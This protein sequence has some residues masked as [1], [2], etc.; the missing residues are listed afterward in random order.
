MPAL[1]FNK[2]ATLREANGTIVDD[3]PVA[4]WSATGGNTSIGRAYD[5]EGQA[6]QN[7]YNPLVA[8]PNRYLEH[9][10]VRYR[11]VSATLHEFLPHVALRLREVRPGGQG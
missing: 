8:A 1:P 5:H 6:P 7:F 2:T 11:I 9:D 10:G 4:I 3:V